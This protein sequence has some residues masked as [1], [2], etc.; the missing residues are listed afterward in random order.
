MGDIN[1]QDNEK[2]IDEFE[3]DEHNISDTVFEICN[4]EQQLYFI[5]WVLNLSEQ[6]L[7]RGKDFLID[8]NTS[9]RVLWKLL[10]HLSKYTVV[11]ENHYVDR[12]YRDSYY[13]YYSSKHFSYSRFCKRLC[14]FRGSLEHD[15]YDCSCE[16]LEKCFMGTIVIRPISDR[17]IS[18]TLLN[19]HFFL[20]KDIA[21]KIRLARYNVMVYGKRLH[22]WAFPYSMQDGETTSCAEIT[23]LNL[24]DYYSQLY[25]EY[26]YLLPSEISSLAEKNSYER[27]M[28]TTGLSYELI[29]KIFCD[30]G[31]YPRLYSA[32]KMT[33]IK[34]R[35]ILYHYVE[36]GIPVALGLKLGEENKHS[37]I[38]IGYAEPAHDRLGKELTCA[39]DPESKNV[40][41]TCDTAD[42]VDTYCIMDDNR[43]PYKLSKCTEEI[44]D[45]KQNTS[46]LKLNECEVEYMMVPLYKRMILEAADAYDIC[47]SILASQKFGIKDFLQT[48]TLSQEL[49]ELDKS[50]S[51]SGTRKEPLVIRLFM[52][53]SRTFRRKRDEQFRDKNCEVRDLYNITVFP[54]FVWVCE[55]TTRELYKLDKVIGE[56]IIDATSS[57]DAK[58]DSFIIIHYPNV[59]CR[60][61]PEEFLETKD[62]EFEKICEWHPFESFHGNLKEYVG[63]VD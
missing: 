59:I 26:H 27:R 17:S 4:E 62:S 23:I 58:T 42:T 46:L 15:F 30:A 40:I 28:P 52:A 24:L 63:E 41:W 49:I 47:L 10:S 43:V 31:F 18:R 35:H 54:K 34:F 50:I 9:F 3:K 7:E 19:P 45:T 56:I 61:M 33:T 44:Q 12:V 38:S 1:T 6:E 39:Y 11:V 22:I 51:D 5:A 2:L 60:R 53:S 13:F 16:E 29:S 55:F 48:D 20:P 36:S 8:H 57:A 14:L 37:V 32:Q 21:C 25:P